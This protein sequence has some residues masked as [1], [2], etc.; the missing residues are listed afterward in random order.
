MEEY[1]SS[2]EVSI[3]SVIMPLYNK[4]EYVEA[5][6]L[7]VLNQSYGRL[8]LI[9]VNDGSTDGSL[10]IVESFGD[11]RIRIISKKNE[12]VA[13]A[14]NQGVDGSQGNLLAFIDADDIWF[15]HHLRNLMEASKRFPSAGMFCN[16]YSRHVVPPKNNQPIFEKFENYICEVASGAPSVWTSAVMLRK[17]IFI[18]TGGFPAGESHGE[19]MSVWVS[20]ALVAPVV[21][22]DYVGAYYRPTADGLA[23][24]LVNYPDGLIRRIDKL[25]ATAQ[26]THE[27]RNGLIDMRT[28]VSIAHGITALRY[29]RK[30][31][32]NTFLLAIDDTGRHK[33]KYILIRTLAY[34]PSWTIKLVIGIYSRWRSANRYCE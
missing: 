19:D 11:P 13:K 2:T 4:A 22:C 29:G 21:F 7:S 20:A 8:E 14:R 12:G 34:L 30:D 5:A 16:A 27:T 31:I 17:S 10:S 6:V 28:S 25:L 18:K 15:E 32:A 3:V 1:S 24:K 26:Y 33:N 9:V 23:S